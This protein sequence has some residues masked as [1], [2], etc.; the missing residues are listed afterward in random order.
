MVGG[1]LVL[2]IAILVLLFTEGEILA[3]VLTRGMKL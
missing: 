2:T 3:D 1:N